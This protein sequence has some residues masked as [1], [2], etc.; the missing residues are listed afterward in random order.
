MSA[1]SAEASFD[2]WELE[3]FGLVGASDAGTVSLRVADFVV[4]WGRCFVVQILLDDRDIKFHVEGRV[5]S[6]AAVLV[7]VLQ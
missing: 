6:W 1:T 5:Q 4:L 7:A 3:L 2:L